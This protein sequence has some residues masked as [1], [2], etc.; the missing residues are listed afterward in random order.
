VSAHSLIVLATLAAATAHAQP[1]LTTTTVTIA[2]T[3]TDALAVDATGVGNG[4]VLIS[5]I[6]GGARRFTRV[7]SAG[8]LAAGPPVPTSAVVAGS[9][10]GVV[11]VVDERGL[12]AL[13][14]KAAGDVVVIAG[15]PLFGVADPTA[16]PLVDLCP[17][18]Q[19]RLLF[20]AGGVMAATV[21]GDGTV[22]DV[23]LL[24]FQHRA[25]AYTGKPG[26]SL[27]GERPY[28]AA[29]SL[30]AP[31]AMSLDVDADGDADLVLVH[32]ARAVVFVRASDGRLSPTGQERDLFALARP[33]DVTFAQD[34]DVRAT[35]VR[36]GLAVT[37]AAGAVPERTDVVVLQGDAASPL[38]RVVRRRVVAG[39]G[40]LVGDS[41]VA[42]VDTSLVSLSG[43]V[44]SGR[45]SLELSPLE[46]AAGRDEVVWGSL[47]TV[48]D[49]R[50]GRIDGALPVAL[51]VDGD[52]KGDIVDLGE[53]GRAV[54]RRVEADRLVEVASTAVPRAELAR[55]LPGN[56]VVFIVGRAGKAG[57]AVALL[58]ARTDRA[59]DTTV[60]RPR[61]E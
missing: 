12:V 10:G 44:L 43:V 49:V 6:V 16:L 57:T 54:W 50:Q 53:P 59:R 61:R 23:R 46:Q 4:A 56:R 40:Q 37:L 26:R 35:P 45:V 39:L 25:R 58:R 14:A 41:I 3:V 2:G 19:E 9:C 13:G 28:A 51:D 52:G 15:A 60:A 30:Y 8:A 17:G 24:P 7:S 20:V 38:S 36:G 5:H 55:A 1:T 48:A 34:V 32:E 27:R 29:L 21:A 42:R 22:V 18:D 33:S 11:H 47:P 31:H